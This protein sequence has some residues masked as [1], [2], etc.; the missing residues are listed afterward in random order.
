MQLL[1][2]LLNNTKAPLLYAVVLG[3]MTAIS[4]CQF[5]RNI[6]AISYISKDIQNTKRVFMNG[7]FYTLGNAAG[8]L[9]IALILFFGA[10]K[11][12][13]SKILVSNGNLLIGLVLVLV[14]ILMLDI[15]KINF[16]VW[17]KLTEKIQSRQF[18]GNK[19][20]AALLGFF[21]AFVLSV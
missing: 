20:N 18:K 3:L 13:V 19:L 6:T 5:A 10:S 7:L 21:C 15:I 11:F 17:S 14:G 1:Q 12:H 4:P 9:S 2:D 16:P 8:Y